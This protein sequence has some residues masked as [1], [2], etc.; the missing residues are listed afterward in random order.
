MIRNARARITE[1]SERCYVDKLPSTI[2]LL[3]YQVKSSWNPSIHFSVSVGF[4]VI[5][6]QMSKYCRIKKDSK[7]CQLA[8]ATAN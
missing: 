6:G 3:F 1:V 5:I 8:L 7:F 4:L 2:F